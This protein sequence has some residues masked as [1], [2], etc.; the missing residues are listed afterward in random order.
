MLEPD[1][2]A[3][4]DLGDP[5]HLD[6]RRAG[7]LLGE[8]LGPALRPRRARAE[9]DLMSVV[10]AIG[11]WSR[12]ARRR[13]PRR[14]ALTALHRVGNAPKALRKFSFALQHGSRSLVA[15]TRFGAGAAGQWVM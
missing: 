2:A 10:C 3:R 1:V 11:E 6:D 8:V 13:D 5:A 9:G 7:P 12:E 14:A 4:V 15:R